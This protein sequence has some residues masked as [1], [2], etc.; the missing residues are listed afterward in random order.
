MFL[1]PWNHIHTAQTL[2]TDL[3]TSEKHNHQKLHFSGAKL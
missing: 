1:A 2:D 3:C